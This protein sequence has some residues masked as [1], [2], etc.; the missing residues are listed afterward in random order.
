MNNQLPRPVNRPANPCFSSGPT[1]KRPGWSASLLPA[2]SL[3]RSHRA[4]GPK[5]RLKYLIDQS[6]AVLEM[7]SDYLVGIV[8][9]SD[10]GAFEMAMWTMLGARGVDVFAWE[11]FGEGWVTDIQK[12]LR[13]TDVRVM[14]AP[15]GSLPDLNTADPARDTVFTWNG[16]TSGVRVPDADWIAAD[17][18]GITLCDATSALFAMAVQWPKLDATT[19]SWQKALGG[20]GGHG[21][22]A[23]SPAAVERLQSYTP[24]WP[25]PK[26]FRLAKGGKL[27]A[28]I[29]EGA[30]INTPSMLAVEDHI[31]ALD[32]AEQIGGLSTLIERS[33]ANLAV[34][35]AWVDQTP[36][37]DFLATDATTRSSTS[38]CLSI[39]DEWF[40]ARDSDGQNQ[41]V[42][43]L[44][45]LL[46]SEGV[47]FDIGSY[48]DAPPG[49]RIWGG[50][51]VESSDVEALLPWIDWGYQTLK[52]A[53]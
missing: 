25:L 39:T 6:K 5:A 50:G 42:K 45:A 12:Q 7:P 19:W 47:G 10:T 16:T 26:L 24:A 32:W 49:L 28:E 31:D 20:E 21:M 17:R 43:K 2:A 44:V 48:R 51:T 8:P 53:G 38:V 40:A 13:L 29:F 3:G 46:E 41:F 14:Q 22:L 9:A 34:I 37:V 30:T 18:T 4:K 27:D 15:Y 1:S 52:S 36:W 23:L 11:S 35:D 33:S